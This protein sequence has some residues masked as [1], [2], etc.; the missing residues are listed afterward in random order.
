MLDGE[1]VVL[2]ADG[3]PDFYAL[4]RSRPTFVAFD[5][6]ELDRRDLTPLHLRDRREILADVDSDKLPLVLRSRPF[7]DGA[8]L[9]VEG[10]RESW[11]SVTSPAGQESVRRAG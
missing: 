6:L 4:W 10:S 2:D 7:L 9:M 1:V 5:I 8:A 11:P 3:R